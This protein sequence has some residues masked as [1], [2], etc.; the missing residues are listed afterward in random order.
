M[1][2]VGRSGKPV[3]DAVVDAVNNAWQHLRIRWRG[4][5]SQR[6]QPASRR[7]RLLAATIDGLLGLAII[8][9]IVSELGYFEAARFDAMSW[10]LRFVVIVLWIAQYLALHGWLLRQ[11]G[12][13][14]GKRIVGIRVA[15]YD[16]DRVPRLHRTLIM[17]HVVFV[18]L[19]Q[20]GLWGSLFY[21][22]NI[23]RIFSADRRCWHDWFAYTWVVKCSR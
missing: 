14:V 21:L 4:L 22:A 9:P 12:Q 6:P 7:S 18:L 19:T 20:P 15:S 5:L 23:G 1:T 16:D 8:A 17:R 13:T 11:Y 10:S 3:T 2:I